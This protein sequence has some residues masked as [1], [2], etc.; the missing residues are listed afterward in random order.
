M[1]YLCLR[2]VPSLLGSF[3]NVCS[4]IACIRYRSELEGM[5][6][7]ITIVILT[8]VFEIV[9]SFHSRKE[10]GRGND[11]TVTAESLDALEQFCEGS[12][13]CKVRTPQEQMY[14]IQ[15]L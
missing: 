3:S 2:F 12:E 8:A 10:L 11:E 13:R 6:Y 1:A 15:T 14:K 7:L 5:R 9:G 4:I